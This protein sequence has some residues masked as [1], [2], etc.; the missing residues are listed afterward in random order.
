MG[1]VVRF[2]LVVFGPYNAPTLIAY[3][4]FRLER[5]G[6]FRLA[7]FSPWPL[8]LWGRNCADLLHIRPPLYA[9]ATSRSPIFGSRTSP[10]PS[11]GELRAC[12]LAVCSEPRRASSN[13]TWLAV[14][15]PPDG[16]PG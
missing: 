9:L 11:T 8:D 7:S 4:R 6:S 12:T 1:L 3:R 15:R 14:T 2:D 16:P 10:A 13:F 5:Q